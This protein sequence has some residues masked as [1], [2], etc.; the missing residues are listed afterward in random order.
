MNRSYRQ[1]EVQ[2]ILQIAIAHQ[3]SEGEFSSQQLLEIAAELDIPVETL[4]AAEQEWCSQQ[5]KLQKRQEFNAFRRHKLQRQWGKYVIVNFFLVLLNLVS[6]GAF[7]WA[8]YITL[9]WGLGLGL[10]TWNL[11]QPQEEHYEKA[12]QRWHRRTQLR[13]LADRFMSRWLSA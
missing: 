9:F 2:Q 7:S 4:E 1:E 5:G 11:F 8:F 10:N 6:S 3:A 13:S 12:F